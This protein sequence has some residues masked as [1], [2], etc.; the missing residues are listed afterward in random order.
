ME[1]SRIN[2]VLKE[3]KA[4]KYGSLVAH[5]GYVFITTPLFFFSRRFFNAPDCFL[6]HTAWVGKRVWL[7]SNHLSGVS[8]DNP[9]YECWMDKTLSVTLLVSTATLYSRLQTFLVVLCLLIFEDQYSWFECSLVE[10][11]F[12]YLVE[13][14]KRCDMMWY[15]SNGKRMQL[16]SSR[17]LIEV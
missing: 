10:L 7:S 13:Q 4:V 15:H 11:G 17:I 8:T 2:R 1:I 12:G 3:Y 14:E 16:K 6:L 9:A 5:N